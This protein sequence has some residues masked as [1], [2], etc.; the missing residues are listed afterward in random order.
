MAR[1]GWDMAAVLKQ[2]KW[3]VNNTH[4]MVLQYVTT[5][6]IVVALVLIS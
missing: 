1:L 2:F 5:L 6:L 4:C 3:L